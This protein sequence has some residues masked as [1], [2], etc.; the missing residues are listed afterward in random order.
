M[1]GKWILVGA[2][3]AAL[4]VGHGAFGAHALKDQLVEAGMLANWETAVRY[5]MWH[6]IALIVAAVLADHRGQRL[7]ALGPIFLVGILCFSGSLYALCLGGPG[8]VFGPITP[9]GGVLFLIGWVMLGL[10]ALRGGPNSS[11]S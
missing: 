3:F 11:Q 10:R 4:A 1:N 2:I 7:G 8:P 6:A 5:Q 9:L